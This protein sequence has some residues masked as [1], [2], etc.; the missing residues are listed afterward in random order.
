[1]F[2]NVYVKEIKI[3]SEQE[4]DKVIAFARARVSAV[5]FRITRSLAEKLLQRVDDY[6]R[7]RGIRTRIT[8]LNPDHRWTPNLAVIGA[9]A[10]AIVGVLTGGVTGMLFGAAAGAA[11][12]MLASHV[13]L[14]IHLVE[15]GDMVVVFPSGP[16]NVVF[17]NVEEVLQ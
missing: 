4:L 9:G 8:V 14:D 3:G 5:K 17:Q 15:L 10:G 16:G 11:T 13:V 2:G 12:G 6:S 7:S 1:M